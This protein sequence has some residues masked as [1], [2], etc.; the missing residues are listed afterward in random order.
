MAYNKL[1]SPS[2][3][4]RILF[5]SL[6]DFFAISLSLYLAFLIRFD[7]NYKDPYIVNFFY[8]SLPFF[9]IVKLSI[10][11]FF[12]MYHLTWRYVGL[13]DFY[14]IFKVIVVS[15]FFLM[16]IIFYLKIDKF[17]GFPRSILIIDSLITLFL[18]S[19][20][21]ISKRLFLESAKWERSPK[22]NKTL[23]LG[24]GNTGEMILRDTAKTGFTN[25]YPVG[26]LD[27]NQNKIGAFIH[28]VKVL[29]KIDILS[30]AIKKLSV[31]AI[32]IAIPAMNHKK[33]KEIYMIAK[34]SN[35]HNV[36]IVPRI[37]DFHQ[38]HISLKSLED[39]S[40][41][42]LLGRKIVEIDYDA[43]EKFLKGKR[44]LITGAG[45]SI[46]SEIVMQICAFR[47]ELIIV[48][49]IDETDIY[50]LNLKIQKTYPYMKNKIIFV[51]GDV[52]DAERVNE[53]FD[54]HQLQIVFHTAAYKHVPILENNCREAI[55]VN[56]LGAYN[57]VLAAKRN[58]IEKYIMISTDKA[59]NPTSIMG[60]TKR[61]A[62]YICNAFNDD[63]ES[64]F[65]SVRFGNVLGSRG[66]VLP[67]FMDQLK[68][69][70]PL[71]VT[72]K[73]VERYFMTIPEAVSLVL[74][75]SVIGKGGD[76]LTLDMGKPV[77]ILKLAE[78][79]IKLHGL[80]PYKDVDIQITGL[81]PGE[82]L[83]EEILTAEEGSSVTKHKKIFKAKNSEKYS[84][85]EI[86]NLIDKF[87]K[88]A[89]L[90]NGSDKEIKMILKNHIKWYQDVKI[91]K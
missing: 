39:I 1:F 26:I 35:I 9:L 4:K 38:P 67:L 27:D 15:S 21:R 44:I 82:K 30:Q 53:I 83:F 57:V 13:K 89:Y 71:T 40:I 16:M 69:G 56:I 7:F 64:E 17:T 55:K 73:D 18:V 58:R 80:E 12:K 22:Q 25:Y 45:G 85:M 62:E 49:E 37:Y 78:E 28:G 52:R 24:G 11:P 74:Q 2:P 68:E 5:F 50:H 63:H 86:E 88:A 54:K 79:L 76:T 19:A 75:A 47:P 77:K 14:N 3:F 61:M 91:S 59:V 33:L 87:R 66:S 51:I 36:K 90:S 48:F 10:F 41:E 72:H 29:G 65:I 20:I 84:P 46:G 32:I 70:G 43:I 60:A 34:K 6:F 8:P 31:K 23:I 81:R 42:D